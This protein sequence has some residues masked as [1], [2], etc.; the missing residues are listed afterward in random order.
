MIDDDDDDDETFTSGCWVLRRDLCLCGFPLDALA[1]SQ[2]ASRF[3]GDSI[4][5]MGRT[6]PPPPPLSLSAGTGPASDEQ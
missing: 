4:L 3:I 2:D 1:S 6:S 5:I